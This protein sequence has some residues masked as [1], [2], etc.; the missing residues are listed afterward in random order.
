[1]R[2]KGS[3]DVLEERRRRAL[4]LL[5]RRLSLNEVARQ[6]GCAASSVMRWR[7]AFD[8]G[9]PAALKVRPAPGRPPKLTARQQQRL[10]SVLLKGAMAHGYRTEL[11]TTARIAEV[12]ARTFQVP[13]HR[14]HV[15][16]L[17]HKLGWSHQKP[18]ARAL[19]RDEQRIAH[20]KR[21][22]W[23]RVKKTPRGW[24]PT[25]SSSTSPGSS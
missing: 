14:D 2:P 15:G 18:E 7:N 5:K 4:A 24:A 12:I 9:G 16:R 11:W 6:L 10:V 17:M 21:R 3:A 25:S 23:P 1:M 20:W 13:Y 19:Q 8:G 22:V